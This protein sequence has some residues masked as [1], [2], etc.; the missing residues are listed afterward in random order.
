[1]WLH[2]K[3]NGILKHAKGKGPVVVTFFYQFLFGSSVHLRVDFGLPHLM[4]SALMSIYMAWV[5]LSFQLLQTKSS[6][7]NPKLDHRYGESSAYVYKALIEERRGKKQ[8]PQVT[9]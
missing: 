3:L 6:L 5:G 7:T 9:E 4:I 8:S 1:M 2:V